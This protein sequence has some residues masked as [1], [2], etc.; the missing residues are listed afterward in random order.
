MIASGRKSGIF[1]LGKKG[2]SIENV[3][4]PNPGVPSCVLR[5]RNKAQYVGH[6]P[7]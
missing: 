1:G 4:F 6:G 3:S 5:E 7:I 2:G